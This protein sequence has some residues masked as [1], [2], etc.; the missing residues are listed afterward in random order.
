MKKKLLIIGAILLVLIVGAVFAIPAF[1]ADPQPTS[2][3]VVGRVRILARLLLVQD[4]ARV[5]AFIAKAQAA[6]KITE[7]QAAKIKEFWTNHHQL[8][9]RKVVLTRLLWANDASK[10][11]TFLDKAVAAGKINSEQAENIMTLWNKV[12]TK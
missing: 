3:P 7:A 8:F 11:Q 5:D 9:T 2:T 12:H 4:E 10:V 6:G 1:A